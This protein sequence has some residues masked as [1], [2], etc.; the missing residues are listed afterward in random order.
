MFNLIKITSLL[1]IFG[2]ITS[3]PKAL[4][5]NKGHY[6]QTYSM[7]C[8]DGNWKHDWKKIDGHYHGCDGGMPGEGTDSKTCTTECY[9]T[10]KDP[11]D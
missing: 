1:L 6:T 7:Y 10:N 4:S 5:D 2:S 8:P 9:Q 3:I 11:Y